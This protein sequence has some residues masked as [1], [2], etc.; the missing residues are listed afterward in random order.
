MESSKTLKYI[1]RSNIQATTLKNVVCSFY[2]NLLDSKQWVEIT[3]MDITDVASWKVGIQ[4]T[5]SELEAINYK[6]NGV[7]PLL[8]DTG[9]Y[10]LPVR[11]IT[12]RWLMDELYTL[13][14]TT[15]TTTTKYYY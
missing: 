10:L 5:N 7:K 12:C 13:Y 4:P 1:T 6:T 3:R 9:K 15:T 2:Y 14:T 11:I 8:K